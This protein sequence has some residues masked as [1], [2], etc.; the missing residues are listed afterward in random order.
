MNEFGYQI[1]KFIAGVW[2]TFSKAALHVHRVDHAG[3]E[4]QDGAHG[5]RHL[6]LD[7]VS[8]LF[9]HRL[10][11]NAAIKVELE[12][13]TFSH[14][15]VA[16]IRPRKEGQLG[17]EKAAQK[18]KRKKR[19]RGSFSRL[20]ESQHSAW[21][22]RNRGAFMQIM[23]HFNII[24]STH[25]RA[26]YTNNLQRKAASCRKVHGGEKNCKQS[27][28]LTISACQWGFFRCLQFHG[29]LALQSIL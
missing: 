26:I 7:R 10:S 24:F 9:F 28:N 21:K 18:R 19:G 1:F 20:H 27:Q 23:A 11:C 17:G 22:I 6:Q 8:S 15:E 13:P 29:R 2:Q 12:R 16:W 3:V 25:K 5:V 4:G 14:C